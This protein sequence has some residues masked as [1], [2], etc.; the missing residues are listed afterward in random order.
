M[1]T[2]FFFFVLNIT[3]NEEQMHNDEQ[4]WNYSL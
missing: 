4:S 3:H 1:E 2:F